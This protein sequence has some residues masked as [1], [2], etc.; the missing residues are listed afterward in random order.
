QIAADYV[1][2]VSQRGKGGSSRTALVISPTHA[3]G[4]RVTEAIR[5][6]LKSHGK[7]APQDQPFTRLV[8]RELRE[9]QRGLMES[10]VP[11]DVVQFWQNAKGFRRGQRVT[12]A[13]IDANGVQVQ[14][15]NGQL[16]ALP[17][18]QAGR[19]EVY[20]SS[21]LFLAAGDRIRITANG[22]TSGG[23]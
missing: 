22:Q 11:G 9:A 3:E 17:L 7:L 5:K 10:Y 21:E 6:A 20:R 1:Q 18:D 19:F 4:E 12:V 2:A 8:R 16:L 13:A 14:T 23:V 15:A